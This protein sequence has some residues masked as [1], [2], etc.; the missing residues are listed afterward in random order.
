M[1]SG[2][3]P[4]CVIDHCERVRPA[5]ADAVAPLVGVVAG[6]PV[7]VSTEGLGVILAAHAGGVPVHR[8][9][10]PAAGAHEDASQL[11]VALTCAGLAFIYVVIAIGL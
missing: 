6:S 3:H 1:V 5:N 7:R 4:V 2:H 11:G 8:C 9:E 10:R